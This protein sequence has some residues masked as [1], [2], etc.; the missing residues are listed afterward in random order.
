MADMQVV[1]VDDIEAVEV[2]PGIVRRRLPET[3]WA[4]GWL[5]D[6]APGTQWPAVDHHEGEERYFVLSGEVIEGDQRHGVGTYVVFAP[7][8][9][10]RPR[11]EIGAR[12]LGVNLPAQ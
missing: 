2:A 1:H 11:T 5:I 4:R 10:H 9:S 8:S 6:F 12:M 3:D 7:G